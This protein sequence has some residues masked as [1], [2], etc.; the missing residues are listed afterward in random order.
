VI[1]V[2]ER[3][4]TRNSSTVSSCSTIRFRSL[5]AL[6]APSMRGQHV[7]V[8]ARGE[9]AFLEVAGTVGLLP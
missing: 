5:A 2:S 3:S 9:D 8:L 4:L 1:S 7:N 6:A